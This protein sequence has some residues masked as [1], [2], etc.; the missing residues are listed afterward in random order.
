MIVNFPLNVI[1][2]V[3][4]EAT[5]KVLLMFR[6]LL[7]FARPLEYLVVDNLK[8]IPD[9][10][11]GPQHRPTS[12]AIMLASAVALQPDQLVI[13]GLDMF[14]HPEGSYPGDRK[15][16]NAYTPAHS[17]DQE[18]AFILFHLEHPISRFVFPAW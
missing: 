10:L 3:P 6:G 9:C 2:G 5:E 1:L 18:L 12:G 4:D 14:R 16:M 15:T 7:S 13:A 11:D 8:D 17:Y